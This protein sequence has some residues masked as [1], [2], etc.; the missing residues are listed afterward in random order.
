MLF[1]TRKNKVIISLV[2]CFTIIISSF[3]GVAGAKWLSMT[4]LGEELGELTSIDEYTPS[5]GLL[6]VLVLGVDES[7]AL[8][9]TIM[10]FSIDQYSSEVNVLSIPRD[11]RILIGSTYYKINATMGIG[12]Q[13]VAKGNLNEP[14]DYVISKVKSITGL[15]IH[16]FVTVDFD[17][18]IDII[19]ALGGVDYDVPYDMN[20]DDPAQ[21]LHIH[22]SAGYQ[23][24]DGQAAHDYVR[25]RH[26]TNGRSPGNYSKGDEGRIEAQQA[27]I[28]E[29]I[30]QKLSGASVA[31]LTDLYAVLNKYVRTNFTGADLAT[32]ISLLTTIR[33]D[34]ISTYQLPGAA[35]YINNVSY[36]IY[37]AAETQELIS[38][39]FK[40]RS[41][42][43]YD[44][45]SDMPISELEALQALESEEAEA[46][47]AAE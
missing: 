39:V 22:L 34:K 2:F 32:H 16:Y 30:N 29:V 6:N 3:A 18:F 41:A 4:T 7:E 11:T 38:T 21:N 5:Y 1:G 13:E 42:L 45:E 20:Y 23:H 35:Q 17:G 15:P 31:Y 9:D 44:L 14:E 37:D 33:A 40:P 36:Y 28:K 10:L 46:A 43:D 26:D 47:E 27:F 24:L 19:D 12:K 25:Y 8:C